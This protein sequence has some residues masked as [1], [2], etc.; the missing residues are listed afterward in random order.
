MK[1]K[2]TC[3]APNLL[4]FWLQDSKLEVATLEKI[5]DEFREWLGKRVK[6][7]GHVNHGARVLLGIEQ[8]KYRARVRAALKYMRSI[9]C[10]V[11]IGRG[12]Y[13]FFI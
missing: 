7:D 3:G 2:Q 11:L 12:K 13:R 4:Y 10:A 9:G 5:Y 6:G 8:E 1:V